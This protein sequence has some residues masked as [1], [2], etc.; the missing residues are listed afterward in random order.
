M[1]GNSTT[2]PLYGPANSV[3]LVFD[4]QSRA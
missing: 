2:L 1:K 4:R 3:N